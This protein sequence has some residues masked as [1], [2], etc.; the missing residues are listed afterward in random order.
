MSI[1]K[2]FLELVTNLDK[3]FFVMLDVKFVHVLHQVSPV[4]LLFQDIPLLE[5][6]L[7]NVRQAVKPVILLIL[8]FVQNVLMLIQW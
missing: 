3:V 6:K 8:H 1:L 7:L 5:V 2:I 4:L